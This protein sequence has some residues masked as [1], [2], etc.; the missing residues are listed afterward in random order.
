MVSAGAA[1][2][3]H[4]PAHFFLIDGY[5]LI[6]RAFFA[7]ISRPLRTSKGENT[8]AAWGVVELPA[9]TPGEVP[10]RLPRLGPRRR[11]FLSHRSV[12]GVQ[13]HPRKARRGAAGRLRPLGRAQSTSCWPP[14]ESRWSRW[15][16]LRGGR[17]DRYPGRPGVERGWQ[18]V[19]R[20]G[21]QGLLSAHRTRRRAAQSGSR[22]PG[23]G[24]RAVGRRRPTRRATGCAAAPGGGLP[25]AWWATASDNIPG[26]KGIGDEGRRRAAGRS[27]AASTTMLAHATEVQSQA[28]PRGAAGPCRRCPAVAAAGDDSRRR[29]GR[30]RSEPRWRKEPRITRSLLKLLAGARVLFAGQTA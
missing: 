4:D 30:A 27:S 10:A 23:G 7:L 19:D 29:A 16:G 2:P 12:S 9:P 26:V 18:V 22:R 6:Y 11:R 14:F 3:N 15:T 24:R 8:S 1:M 28:G 13:V 21:R 20:V 25:R 17:R 5:A